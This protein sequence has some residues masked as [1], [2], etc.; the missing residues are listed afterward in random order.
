MNNNM[1]FSIQDAIRMAK[2]PAG[3]QLIAMLQQQNDPNLQKA[4]NSASAGDYSG[5]K[6]ALSSMLENPEIAA[7]LK[8]LGGENG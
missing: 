7:L 4:V 6:T 8:Q 2:T 5:A 3:Q 1:D